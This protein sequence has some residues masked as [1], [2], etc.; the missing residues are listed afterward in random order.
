MRIKGPHSYMVTSLGLCMK[1]PLAPNVIHEY[2][3]V[4]H[5]V[6]PM[7]AWVKTVRLGELT[8]TCPSFLDVWITIG[9]VRAIKSWLSIM[10]FPCLAP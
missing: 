1:W 6:K 5:K 2:N 10:K 9:K 7:K 4:I 3:R 8:Q